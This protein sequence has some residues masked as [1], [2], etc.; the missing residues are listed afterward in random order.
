[1][2]V[3]EGEPAQILHLAWHEKL[4]S[5]LPDPDYVIWTRPNIER[6]RGLAVAAYCRRIVKQ[7]TRQQVPYGFSQPDDFFDA[8]GS[9]VRGPSKVGLTCASFV[10]A[11]FQK[12]GV[13][14]ARTEEWPPATPEDVV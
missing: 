5:D 2:R 9:F 8:D 10:L 4:R 7:A 12:A 11:L 3:S 13:S 6:D 1:Y 14:L